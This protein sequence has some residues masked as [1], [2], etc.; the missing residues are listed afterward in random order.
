MTSFSIIK[1]SETLKILIV[2]G[3]FLYGTDARAVQNRRLARTLATANGNIVSVLSFDK[4]TDGQPGD[5]RSPDETEVVR[6]P[7]PTA[8]ESIVRKVNLVRSRVLNRAALE[9]DSNF[10]YPKS[11][12][13]IGALRRRVDEFRPDVAIFVATP[14][15]I[16]LLGLQLEHL[17]G[18][19]KVAFFSDPWPY[20]TLPPPFNSPAIP[21]AG[22][23]NRNLISR[24]Y[25]HFDRILYTNSSAVEFML[26]SY[27]ELKRNSKKLAVVAHLA[28]E[29]V[30]TPPSEIVER[31]RSSVVHL[32]VLSKERFTPQLKAA[33]AECINTHGIS[34]TFIGNVCAKLRQS[35]ARGEF[36]NGVSL[37]DSLPDKFSRYI[38]NRAS[39]NLIVEADIKDSPFLPSKLTD[40]LT[41]SDR[42]VF[43][44]G[45]RRQPGVGIAPAETAN[46]LC[47]AHDSSAIVN[48]VLAVARSGHV[49][50]E[51]CVESLRASAIERNRNLANKFLEQ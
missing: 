1:G 45:T 38:A 10:I 39:V 40:V 33:M 28:D 42:W 18:M 37:V 48:A 19:R 23:Y 50:A 51:P 3:P 46:G 41:S 20:A 31:I 27:P 49:N 24:V 2:C 4:G 5:V 26:A 25:G 8:T 30:E 6:V 9:F 22:H 36:G 15:Y 43:V 44:S 16:P 34:F 17:S 35:L 32:G 11:D 21:L 12:L 47:V 29:I 14:Y 7:L 13:L